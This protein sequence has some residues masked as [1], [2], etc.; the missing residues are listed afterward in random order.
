MDQ[1]NTN[2]A[3]LT[4]RAVVLLSGGLD[5]CVA[6]AIA[7]HEGFDCSAIAFDYGQRH[8]AE[9]EA[10]E[11]VADALGAT[12]TLLGVDLRAIGGSALTDRAIDV[13]K[14]RASGAMGQ[15]VPVTYV[16]ARNLIFLSIATAQAEV[17][18]AS[19]VF[20]GVNAIDYSGYPDCR[21]AFIDAFSAAANLATRAG[22]QD[23][24][25]LTIATPL[26][27]MSKAQ[28]IQRGVQLGAPLHLTHSCYDPIDREGQWLH[29]GR[30]DSCQ[31]R[32]KGF[33]DAGV[34]DP[35]H[36]AR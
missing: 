7:R 17:T 26:V 24:R 19:H 16:P 21:Q 14:D 4:A 12:H 9:L 20:I 33:V 30:C 18:G 15:G 13:P 1:S 23:A 10:S 27:S 32:A 34:K 25:T 11:R 31:I 22:T 3:S 35:T 6:L 8:D 2:P 36:Y 29:C 5:S 28:I